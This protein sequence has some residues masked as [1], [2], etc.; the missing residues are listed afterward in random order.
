MVSDV[1]FGKN[2]TYFILTP[3]FAKVTR[4]GNDT[5]VN[6]GEC[7]MTLHFPEGSKFFLMPLQTLAAQGDEKVEAAQANLEVTVGT[8]LLGNVPG[9]GWAVSLF[10]VAESGLN[11]LEAVAAFEKIAAEEALGQVQITSVPGGRRSGYPDPQKIPLVVLI[12]SQSGEKITGIE[13]T[14]EQA[15]KKGENSYTTVARG[16]WDL[17]SLSPAAPNARPVTLSDYPPFQL[18]PPEVQE[19]LLRHFGAL[20]NAEAWQMP[21]VTSLLP[22]YPNPFNPETWIP[23]QLA[24]PANVTLVIYNIQGRVVHDL[25]L[26]HQRAGMYHTRS[27]AAYWDSR[28]AHGEPVASGVYFYTLTAGDFSATKKMLIRK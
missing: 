27:R 4:F 20:A 10:K 24:E 26:G 11:Y 13:F 6:Y 9:A 7:R 16:K 12:E 3:K 21:E 18:L 8:G 2:S 23:Y 28:N 25:D 22:N 15:Y 17:E 5:A 1:A 19:Y 14:I